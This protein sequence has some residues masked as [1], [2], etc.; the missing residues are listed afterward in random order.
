[1]LKQETFN[2]IV[3]YLSNKPYIEVQPLF[4]M[5]IKDVNKNSNPDTATNIVEEVKE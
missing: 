3:Q 1:M 5:I 4:E 2:A